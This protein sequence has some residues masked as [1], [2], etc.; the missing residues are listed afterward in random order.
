[1]EENQE[2][3]TKRRKVKEK[4]GIIVKEAIEVVKGQTKRGRIDF[5]SK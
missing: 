3:E 5:R 4:I 1:V 2:E